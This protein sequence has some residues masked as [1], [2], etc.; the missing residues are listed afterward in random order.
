[1]KMKTRVRPRDS[2]NFPWKL[3]VYH[4]EQGK[5][6]EISIHETHWYPNLIAR[7]LSRRST[8]EFMSSKDRK[9]LFVEKLKG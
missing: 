8:D 4:P 3:E 1:M 2:T 9:N 7:I 5:W 6:Y